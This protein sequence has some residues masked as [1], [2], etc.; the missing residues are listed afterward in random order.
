[1]EKDD[2]NAKELAILARI[3]KELRQIRLGDRRF[4]FPVESTI[5]GDIEEVPDTLEA[6]SLV[7]EMMSWC[8]TSIA[9][10]LYSSEY[11]IFYASPLPK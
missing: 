4:A 2:E 5:L 8:N 1:M 7:E 9:E 6:R 3:S 10:L 11:K